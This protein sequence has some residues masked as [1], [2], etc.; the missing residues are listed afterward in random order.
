MCEGVE[1]RFPH[2]TATNQEAY[3]LR[4]EKPVTV[5]KHYQLIIPSLS[6]NFPN[7]S[8]G[9]SSWQN[10]ILSWTIRGLHHDDRLPCERARSDRRLPAA[11]LLNLVSKLLAVFNMAASAASGLLL[12][13]KLLG[14]V[15]VNQLG[16]PYFSR[17]LS[18]FCIKICSCLNFSRNY[19]NTGVLKTANTR[20]VRH[21]S[22]QN[23]LGE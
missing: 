11:C 4:L 17:F 13:A 5:S 10:N 15:A 18:P 20:F 16:S 8:E 14:H 3:S 7:Y 9:Y 6:S 12:R 22:V 1:N 21:F 19:P 23:W 2:L